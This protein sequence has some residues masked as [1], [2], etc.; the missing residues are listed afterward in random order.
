MFSKI[1][2]WF[3]HASLNL[4]VLK[5]L[6]MSPNSASTTAGRVPTGKHRQCTVLPKKAVRTRTSNRAKV[7]AAAWLVE[8]HPNSGKQ[9]SVYE[10]IST[11]VA[12]CAVKTQVA[13][14]ASA[15]YCTVTSTEIPR[16]NCVV[17]FVHPLLASAPTSFGVNA[18]TEAGQGPEPISCSI[19]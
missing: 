9:M 2:V 7:H 12:T 3:F 11:P 13:F 4:F 8:H 14:K 6:Q 16:L 1:F 19:L 15:K 17:V 5:L 10:L 18:P